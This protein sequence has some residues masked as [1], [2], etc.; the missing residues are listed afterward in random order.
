MLTSKL[1]ERLLHDQMGLNKTQNGLNMPFKCLNRVGL[2]KSDGLGTNLA[3]PKAYNSNG[4]I[5]TPNVLKWP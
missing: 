3:Q 5:Y 2:R 1:L 4:G